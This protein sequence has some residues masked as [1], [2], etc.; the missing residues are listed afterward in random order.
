MDRP[1]RP[2]QAAADASA[3]VLLA[4]YQVAAQHHTHFMGLIWQVPAITIGV[5]GLLA[6]I[7]F[8]RDVPL[9]ARAVILLVGALFLFVMTLSLERYRMFQ[10]RRRRDMEMIEEELTRRGGRRIPWS[11][12]EI[13]AEIDRGEFVAPRVALHRYEGYGLLRAFMYLML[14]LLLGL[15]GLTIG[16][17]VSAAA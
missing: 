14:V 1:V 4:Q 6:G 3:Q 8:G 11:G 7:S 12:S 10:L 2:T 17:M 16:Q 9:L 13:A 15:W 5:V